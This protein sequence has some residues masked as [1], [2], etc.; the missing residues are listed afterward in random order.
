MDFKPNFKTHSICFLLVFEFVNKEKHKDRHHYIQVNTYTDY[1][2]KENTLFHSIYN[3]AVYKSFTFHVLE[4]VLMEI[5]SYYV[6]YVYFK[7]K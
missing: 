2:T 1:I 6:W 5:Y 3:L 4:K 7:I